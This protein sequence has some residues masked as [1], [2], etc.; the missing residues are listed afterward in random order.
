MHKIIFD[1]WW[2]VLLFAV[3]ERADWIDIERYRE[4]EMERERDES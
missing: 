3:K 2:L 4:R 1:G